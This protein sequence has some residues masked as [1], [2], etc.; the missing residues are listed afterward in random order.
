MWQAIAEGL[1]LAAKGV[2]S[3][4][5]WK[6]AKDS[7]YSDTAKAIDALAAI[8]ARMEAEEAGADSHSALIGNLQSGLRTSGAQQ[9]AT[10]IQSTGNASQIGEL[11]HQINQPIEA[12][13]A[14]EKNRIL[15]E[16]ERRDL[17]LR[18]GAFDQL[19]GIE[20]RR[21]QFADQRHA[22]MQAAMYGGIDTI[23]SGV[24]DLMGSIPEEQKTD[25]LKKPVISERPKFDVQQAPKDYIK[26]KL[27]FG[28]MMAPQSGTWGEMETSPM[29]GL[30]LAVT[31][32]KRKIRV[33]DIDDEAGD[34]YGGYMQ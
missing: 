15:Q 3:Y 25:T 2:G 28:E 23:G 16:E 12:Q 1:G 19:S 17:E 10:A 26:Q 31:P 8:R 30:K 22:A 18:E 27:H 33:S 5:Q 34:R 20:Q 21:Q 6:S 24:I 14:A 7:H 9:L 4:Q 13:I 32:P 11:S 29:E